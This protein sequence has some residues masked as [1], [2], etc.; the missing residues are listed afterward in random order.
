[1][2]LD[3]VAALPGDYNFN[4]IVDAAD[5]TVW[6]NS[7]GQTGTGLVADG[8]RDDL[9][10]EADYGIWKSHFGFTLGNGGQAGGESSVV[11]EPHGLVLI[12]MLC[13]SLAA[14]TRRFS[15]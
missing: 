8:N 2:F 7:L 5:Y 9:V 11:P 6:R 12:G 15:M 4:G 10:D 13:I 14:L 1:V 3:V